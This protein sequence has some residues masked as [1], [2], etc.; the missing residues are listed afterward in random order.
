MW[1]GDFEFSALWIF[2]VQNRHHSSNSCEL[3]EMLGRNYKQRSCHDRSLPNAAAPK[4]WEKSFYW[5]TLG[6]PFDLI[7][8]SNLTVRCCTV[9]PRI[10]GNI[11]CE[12]LLL[13]LLFEF[14]ELYWLTSPAPSHEFDVSTGTWMQVN[15]LRSKY[16]WNALVA[17]CRTRSIA[18][19]SPIPARK[20]K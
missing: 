19:N 10:T 9:S 15:R 13:D 6:R 5:N 14:W 12:R 17:A 11:H 7:D 3:T 18:W 20:C 1:I 2:R 16:R 4:R 8:A